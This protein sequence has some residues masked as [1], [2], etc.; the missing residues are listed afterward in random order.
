MTLGTET[1]TFW[2]IAQYL[3]QLHCWYAIIL[4]GGGGL[5]NNKN[6]RFSV[7]D[8]MIVKSISFIFPINN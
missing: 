2:F 7:L 6:N 4:V 1:E 8:I 3:T 5:H